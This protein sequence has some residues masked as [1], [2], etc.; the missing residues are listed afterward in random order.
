MAA[1]GQDRV[2]L[3]LLSVPRM[4][5]GAYIAVL[6]TLIKKQIQE[7]SYRVYVTDALKVI[8]ENTAKLG[9]GSYLRTRY[10]DIENPPPEEKRTPK[11]IINHMKE[12]ITEIR[13]DTD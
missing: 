9:G 8:T 1:A 12:K 7:Q 2:I 4:R 13:G 11:D 3:A 6:P 5:A 10:Y